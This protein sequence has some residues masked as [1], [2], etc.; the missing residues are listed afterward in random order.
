MKRG[1]CYIEEL[2]YHTIKHFNVKTQGAKYFLRKFFP[3]YDMVCMALRPI[4][5][6]V[7][8]F[9]DTSYRIK[10]CQLAS[11]RNFCII[12]MRA[13][14]FATHPHI[15]ILNFTEQRLAAMSSMISESS[16]VPRLLP[17]FIAQ[18]WKKLGRSFFHSCAMKSGS[19]LGTRLIRKTS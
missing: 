9:L 18:L 2:M 11:T 12:H 13:L 5:C 15:N 19:G 3:L 7:E 17:D 1:M 16:L 8:N 14:L 6:I 4:Q 10:H